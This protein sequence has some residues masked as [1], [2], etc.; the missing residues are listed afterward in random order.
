MIIVK[1]M[2][3]LGN[4]MFQYA[5]ARRLAYRHKAELRLDLS[6]FDNMAEIDTPRH[7]ELNC[8]KIIGQPADKSELAMVLPQDFHASTTFRIK[9]RLGV[10]KRIRPLGE[11]HK[12][13]NDIVLR[14]RDNTYL[15]GWWQNENYFKDVRETILQEFQPKKISSRTTQTLKK[16]ESSPSVSLHVR[17]GDYVT[18]K[19]ANKNHGL[20]PIDYYRKAVDLI[21]RKQKQARYFVFSDDVE[22]CKKN[23][24]LGKD[25]VFIDWNSERPCEDIWLMQHCSHNITANSSFSWWGAWLNNNPE[26]IIIAPKNWFKDRSDNQETQ[27]VPKDWLRL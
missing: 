16:I 1:L 21:N 22:W 3:G 23:L 7:Y 9:R 17:R 4:Q 24:P 11:Q 20:A 25:V 27:I 15:L 10:D 2:G 12:G 18:N 5:T 14:A 6:A 19:Y 13:F 26:K 8:Y